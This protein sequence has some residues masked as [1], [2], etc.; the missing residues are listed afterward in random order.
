LIYVKRFWVKGIIPLINIKNGIM[1]NKLLIL[2][3]LSTFVFLGCKKQNEKL[4]ILSGKIV[5]AQTLL[6]IPNYKISLNYKN[7]S[8]SMGFGLN[9]RNNIAETTTN[10]N[11][12]YSLV[13]KKNYA[14]DSTDTY[15]IQARWNDEY[16]GG[17]KEINAFKAESAISSY[18]EDIIVFKNLKITFFI[19]HLGVNNSNDFVLMGFKEVDSI[20][21]FTTARSE[22]FNGNE[23][24]LQ[25]Q[26]YVFP[27]IKYEVNRRGRK[28]NII[29]GPIKDTVIF[30]NT[31]N[32]YNIYY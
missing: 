11:G 19:N 22:S 28:N 17:G 15:L 30:T 14:I 3:T 18:L 7:P 29:F 31:N 6:P 25:N 9:G 4:L 12:E 5:D 2:L 23:P 20:T 8:R 13:S 32:I 26:Y 16:F 10:N 21:T 1:R 27:N 24:I